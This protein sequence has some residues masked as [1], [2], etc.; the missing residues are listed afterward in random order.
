[1]FS[2]LAEFAAIGV[3]PKAK[4]AVHVTGKAWGLACGLW[5]LALADGAAISPILESLITLHQAVYLCALGLWV[6][7]ARLTAIGIA[8]KAVLAVHKA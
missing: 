4:G 6:T 2:T 1:M 3:R 7:F 8:E 5:V